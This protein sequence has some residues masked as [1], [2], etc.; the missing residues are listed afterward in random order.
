MTPYWRSSEGKNLV[1]GRVEYDPY[2]TIDY[3]PVIGNHVPLLPPKCR[4]H[5]SCMLISFSVRFP[6]LRKR[7]KP[8]MPFEL[9]AQ[10]KIS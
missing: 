8:P 10:V 4:P 7:A 5:I 9:F 1:L 2:H 3:L 6:I